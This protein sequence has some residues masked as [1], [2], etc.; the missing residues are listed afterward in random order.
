MTKIKPWWSTDEAYVEEFPTFS[1]LNP[2]G[3]KGA[4]AATAYDLD[5]EEELFPAPKKAGTRR[6]QVKGESD[7]D[8]DMVEEPVAGPSRNKRVSV[9]LKARPVARRAGD[10]FGALIT[11]ITSIIY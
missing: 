4:D 1:R 8:V 11:P 9:E 2:K 5:E 10:N 7:S 6:A 3:L